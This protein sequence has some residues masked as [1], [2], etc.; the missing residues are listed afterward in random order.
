MK[1]VFYGL[2][3]IVCIVILTGCGR[4]EKTLPL[5]VSLTAEIDYMIVNKSSLDQKLNIESVT[6]SKNEVVYTIGED[7][8]DDVDS[9]KA[10]IDLD[11]LTITGAG[12]YSLDDLELVAYNDKGRVVEDVDITGNID[13]EIVI[14]SYSK[15]VP[16]KVVP[17]GELA[18]GKAISSIQINGK[19]SESVTI[20]GREQDLINVSYIEAK[21]D[22]SGL[23]ND[24]DRS[25]LVTLE[26]PSGVKTMSDNSMNVVLK[27]GV[28]STRTISLNINKYNGLSDKLN[29]DSLSDHSVEVQLLGTED[30]INIIDVNNMV[31]YIDLSNLKAGTHEVE[32]RIDGLDERIQYVVTKRISAV[33]SNK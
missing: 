12:T 18:S 30:I 32:V 15:V 31:A 22:V 2:C 11:S 33:L 5:S 25:S 26:K 14:S 28:A 3:L 16:V 13:A 27:F 20:Y 10:I 7:Y 1:K 29:L 4:E 17:I 23:G 6:L 24:G 9:I 19:T 8:V 21:I